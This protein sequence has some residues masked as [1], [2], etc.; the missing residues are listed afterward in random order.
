MKT[1]ILTG[2]K[3]GNTHQQDRRWQYSPARAPPPPHP[4]F[5]P[6]QLGQV[7]DLQPDGELDP[8]QSQFYHYHHLIII[9]TIII[10]NIIKMA[11]KKFRPLRIFA[12]RRGRLWQGS[13]VLLHK[14]LQ[15][16]LKLRWNLRDRNK[17]YLWRT[18]L[19]W[20]HSWSEGDLSTLK[21]V[22]T[23]LKR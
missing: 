3:D 21:F 2:N 10:T 22:A 1:K 9:T 5:L 7:L 11:T 4:T 20:E 13:V 14:L 17:K 23:W 18:N 16:W 12:I 19:N 8:A 6:I 15:T